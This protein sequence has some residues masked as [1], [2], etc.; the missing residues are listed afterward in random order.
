MQVATFAGGCF[1]CTEAVFQRIKG[2]TKVTSGYS[3]GEME[4]PSYERVSAGRTGHAEAIQI[5][6]DPSIISFE[7][8]LDIF[9]AT[10]DP[11]TLNKQ[12]NDEGTQYRSV[13]FYHDASQKEAAERSKKEHQKNFKDEVVTEIIPFEKFYKAED[14]HQDYYN[15]NQMTNA[16]CPI[17]ITPKITKLIEKFNS[18]IKE[19]YRP[20]PFSS[21]DK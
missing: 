3:G 2:V 16:Y 10:H 4:N 11:T 15:Q 9:F 21:E 12:G 19:E 17:I 6:F 18:D 13:I 1:W 7:H 20:K 8:L 5:E 14:Y